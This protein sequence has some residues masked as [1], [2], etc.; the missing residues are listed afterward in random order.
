MKTRKRPK[1]PA[2][3]RTVFER[4]AIAMCTTING[5][6]RCACERSPSVCDVMVIAAQVAVRIAA[7]E[8]FADIE[9]DDDRRRA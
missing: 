7:P 4:A 9:R 2:E 6:G 1:L 3:S 5:Q 8:A